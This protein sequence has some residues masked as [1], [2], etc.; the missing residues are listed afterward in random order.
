MIKAQYQNRIYKRDDLGE[1]TL[2]LDISYDSVLANL[3]MLCDFYSW[4]QEEA[5]GKNPMYRT[6]DSLKYFAVL[7]SSWMN[8][9]PLSRMISNSIK[10]YTKKEEIWDGDK[11]VPFKPKSKSHINIVV[12]EIISNVDN[13]LRFKLKN[14][15]GNYYEILVDRLGKDKAGENWGEFLEYGT[16]DLRIIELQNFG[17]PRHLANYLLQHYKEFFEFENNILISVDRE[18]L[19]DD[20]DSN[21]VEFKELLEVL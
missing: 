21:S 15:F 5:S 10:Y 8:S 3:K 14:Y 6:R 7:M 16:T 13:I 18:K 20:M 12:N 17:I 1:Y 9:T 19:L 2:P 11:P 4:D